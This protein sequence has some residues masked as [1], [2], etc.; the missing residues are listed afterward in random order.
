MR[1]PEDSICAASAFFAPWLAVRESVAA[2]H[3]CNQIR[4]L[5]D[6]ASKEDLDGIKAGVERTSLSM[7]CEGGQHEK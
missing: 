7:S 1:A 3:N 2:D 5:R 4:N 6:S